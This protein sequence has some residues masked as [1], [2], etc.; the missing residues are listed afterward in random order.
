MGDP[1]TEPTVEE[2]LLSRL[3]GYVAEFERQL[4]LLEQVTS[5][6][7]PDRAASCGTAIEMCRIALDELGQRARG[8]GEAPP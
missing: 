2:L 8:E 3:N 5:Q 7:T 6:L 1:V 4:T